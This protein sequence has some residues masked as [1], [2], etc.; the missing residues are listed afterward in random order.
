MRFSAPTKGQCVDDGTP[1]GTDVIVVE[2]DRGITYTATRSEVWQPQHGRKLVM[3]VG[4]SGGYD[5][6]R[7]Y[8]FKSD[9]Q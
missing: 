3:L 7:V 9:H 5:A 8:P 6:A 2:D 1:S 4:R